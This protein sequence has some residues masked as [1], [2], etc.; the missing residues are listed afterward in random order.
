MKITIF[1]LAGTGTSTVGKML[2][3]KLGLKFLSAGDIFRRKAEDMGLTLAEL[4]DLAVNDP[5]MD[6]ECDEE[7]EKFGK[8]ND[9]FVVESRLSWHFI[10]DSI[11]IKLDT[12]LDTRVSRVAQ[13]DWLLWKNA[14]EGV[15][16]RERDDEARYAKFYGIK[17]LSKDEHF[18][19]I[20]DT[21]QITPPQV[22]DKIVEL[23]NN[24]KV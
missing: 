24:R 13:R 16:K 2:A 15:L 3:E 1:G 18:D 17:D 5:S 6:K 19:I 9:D 10:P 4:H 12:D 7:I 14:K 22:V 11:K 23:V 8:E 21:S 20:I